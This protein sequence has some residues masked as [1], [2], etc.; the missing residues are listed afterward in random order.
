MEQLLAHLVGD[1]VFQNHWM[2]NTKTVKTRAALV[3][4][5]TY[6]LPFLLLTSSWLALLVI[7]STHFVIDRF[8]LARLWVDFWGTGKSGWVL[9]KLMELRGYRLAEMSA[10][11]EKKMKWWV[12]AVLLEAASRDPEAVEASRLPYIEEAPAFLAVWLLIIVDNTLHLLINYSAL[13]W[14]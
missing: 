14:L 12:P 9:T 5:L 10:A 7:G 13:R 2:A 3:H 8:R 6:S 1:Y 11:D 4:A